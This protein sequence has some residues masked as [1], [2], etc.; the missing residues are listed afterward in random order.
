M[1]AIDDRPDGG[2]GAGGG[3]R[4][5]AA[6]ASRKERLDRA[7]W[8]AMLGF[9]VSFAVWWGLTLLDHH[10]PETL[11]TRRWT[12]AL[13][14]SSLLAGVAWLYF[15]WR[16]FFRVAPEIREDPDLERALDDEYTRRV[17]TRS[18]VV[19]YWCL[20]ATQGLLLLGAASLWDFSGRLAAGIGVLVGVVAPMVA[21]LV[22]D[23]A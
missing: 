17:R 19:G 20:L 18:F 9:T 22:L 13:V 7:R 14:V 10:L 1:T 6:A 2:G 11:L 8:R 4:R 15:L 5:G 12:A 16:L 3:E 21:C 23:R